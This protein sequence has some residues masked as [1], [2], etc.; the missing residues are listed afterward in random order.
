RGTG[1]LAGTIV[2]D[3]SRV[4]A[5]PY[6]TM[7]LADLGATVIKVEGRMGDDTRHWAP[8]RRGDDA[9]YFL[10]ANRNKHSDVL[11]FK[12]PEDLEYSQ[13]RAAPPDTPIETSKTGGLAKYGPSHGTDKAAN[14]AIVYASATGCGRDSPLPGYDLRSLGQSGF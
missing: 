14:P 8:P 3:F 10:T 12:D 4:L 7:M 9:T 2:A 5:G 6:A 1:P 13:R 11:D